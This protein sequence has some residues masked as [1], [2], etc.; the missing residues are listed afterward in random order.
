MLRT[1]SERVLLLTAFL[2]ITTG[3]CKP[4]DPITHVVVDAEKS[5]IEFGRKSEKPVMVEGRMLVG[6]HRAEKNTW[7]FKV[8]GPT[9]QIDSIESQFM[10]F[11]RMV[12][13][14]ND[15]PV[16]TELPEGWSK[17]PGGPT[18]FIYARVTV[19]NDLS[20]SISELP[21]RFNNLENVNRWR[22]Q[23][24]LPPAE[25]AELKPLTGESKVSIE[26]FDAKGMVSEGGVKPP[27]AGM[28]GGAVRQ[29]PVSPIEFEAPE[30]W[31]AGEVSSMV[32]AKFLKEDGDSKGQMT[33]VRMPA[34]EINKWSQV[35]RNWAAEV[36]LESLSEEE[37]NQRTQETT[38][39]SIQ[40]KMIRLME[41]EGESPRGLVGIRL[42]RGQDVWFVKLK[43]DKSIVSDSEE[44]F[45]KFVES[46]R[47]K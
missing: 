41:E 8:V 17:V 24:S 16:L 47:F 26:V 7:T 44:T 38:V 21:T 18:Q 20:M 3:G 32:S 40:G 33:V 5:A 25:S 6:I 11:L 14:S 46:V 30:G 1:F 23:L 43:G 9:D 19:N 36:G 39:D 35:S 27:F 4:K 31:T 10:E 22:G 2:L 42:T 15:V 13:I 34:L 37:L 12:D 45:E 29:P 28:S